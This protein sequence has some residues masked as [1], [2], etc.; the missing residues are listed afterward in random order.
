MA[1]PVSVDTNVLV[2][3]RDMR[4]AE[5]HAGARE[6]LQVLWDSKRVR[7]SPQVLV[8]EASVRA[9]RPRQSA[10]ESGDRCGA[11]RGISRGQSR[12]PGREEKKAI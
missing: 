6:W 11:V 7:V 3:S 10:G 9:S 4:D 8:N 2:Y 5:K 12:H 1:A